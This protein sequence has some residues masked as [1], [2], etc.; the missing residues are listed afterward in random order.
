MLKKLSKDSEDTKKKKKDPSH[1]LIYSLGGLFHNV[2]QI[3]L[4][5]LN[6]LQCCQL[7]LMK[8]KTKNKKLSTNQKKS[9]GNQTS[10]EKNYNISDEDYIGINC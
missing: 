5:T 6:R 2:Y 7:Y 8:L 3:V 10:R 4:Y 1:V 9:D